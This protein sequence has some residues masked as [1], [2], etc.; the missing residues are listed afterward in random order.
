MHKVNTLNAMTKWLWYLHRW[1]SMLFTMPLRFFAES[2]LQT[3]H[4]HSHT[5]AQE[6][7]PFS[8]VQRTILCLAADVPSLPAW[9]WTIVQIKCEQQLY[10]IWLWICAPWKNPPNHINTPESRGKHML[11]LFRYI[12]ND[13]EAFV[14]QLTRKSLLYTMYLN[15]VWE[16]YSSIVYLYTPCIIA[17]DK[18]WI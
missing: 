8:I 18:L 2:T 17:I 4:T 5:F 7:A 3:D 6:N 10:G 1:S 14:Q 12:S 16:Q 9:I 11:Q 15:E 13:N